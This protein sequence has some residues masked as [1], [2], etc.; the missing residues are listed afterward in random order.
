[1]PLRDFRNSVASNQELMKW[2]LEIAGNRIHG[3]TREKP[4]TL[5]TQ[6]EALLIKPLPDKPPELAVWK[7]I[8]VR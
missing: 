8:K 6:T 4:L 3:T 1:M 2:N 7:K 5:F